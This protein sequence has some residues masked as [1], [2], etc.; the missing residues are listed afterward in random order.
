MYMKRNSYAEKETQDTI[1][2]KES[3][4]IYIQMSDGQEIFCQYSLGDKTKSDIVF[5]FV[6]GFASGYFTWSD[7]W[8][9]L[10]QEFNL[11]I[12]DP[13][14]KN[15][16]KLMK[17]SE[18]SVHRMALDFAEAIKF[19]KLDEKKLVLFGSSIGASYVAH[20][21]GQNMITPKG[22]FLTGPAIKPRAPNKLIKF[23]FLFPAFALNFLGK[24]V[25]R[26]YLRN[27]VADGFQKQ[28]FYDRINNTDF[29]RWKHCRDL[30]DW[31]AT[32]DFKKMK[33]PV[34][35]VRTPNDKY[36]VSDEIQIIHELILNSKF[37]DVQTYDYCHTKPSVN[38][39]TQTIKKT[40][41][42]AM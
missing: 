5:F 39:F 33:I 14:E 35:I 19:L 41:L 40:I 28:V 7:F 6:Q 37:I 31:D 4:K 10:H 34:F 12:V 30:H 42:E 21:V 9:A 25:A 38:E 1:F 20:L 29:R 32:E 22:C 27:K 15:S 3:R 8:D 24:L 11:V 16:N 13:R 17:S 26:I 2:L 23:L 18:C 36:H